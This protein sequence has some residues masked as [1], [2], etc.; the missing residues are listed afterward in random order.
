MYTLLLKSLKNKFINGGLKQLYTFFKQ[1]PYKRNINTDSNA[2][3]A[4]L[5]EPFNRQNDI[6]YLNKHQNRRETLIIDKVFEQLNF[7]TVFE[8]FDRISLKK[9]K[10]DLIFGLEPNFIIAVNNN[11]NSI[12]IYYATGAYWKHQNKMIKNRT[13]EFNKSH[14]C[15]I[16]ESRIVK[17]HNASEI[18]D[19]IIQIGSKFTIE[20]YP[21]EL[22]NKI[23]TI[24][25]SCH[26]FNF[27]NFINR[28]LKY[29]QKNEFIWMGSKGSILKGLDLILDYFINHPNSVLHVI[30][31]IDDD[32]FNFYKDKIN[33][34]DNIIIH[35]FL[36][37][38]SNKLEEIAI[39]SSFVVM[40]SGSEGM[41]GAVINMMKLGCIPIV[42]KY[43]AFDE[44]ENYGFLIKDFTNE[45]IQ[46]TIEKAQ[47]H[48]KDE[49]KNLIV[50]NYEFSNKN[51]NLNNFEKDL[52]KALIFILDKTKKK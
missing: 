27:D 1:K 39:R 34:T 28:K 21:Q 40:P 18:A 5:S 23:I 29:F 32:I 6:S 14:N 4:Y 52:K 2:Y 46:E 41:P 20:T 42:T 45:S 10:Y 22:R 50:K 38:D 3:V 11:P 13:K 15:N 31:P 43:A 33:K 7:S 26:T 9:S 30:G 48:N 49:I 51:F 19:Y 37:L 47:N 25:Q 17:A 36:D 16:S 35:G 12:K 44:I 8:R 24:R